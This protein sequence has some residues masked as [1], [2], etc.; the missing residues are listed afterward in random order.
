MEAGREIPREERRGG[1]GVA[2]NESPEMRRMHH[3]CISVRQG[4]YN[5]PPGAFPVAGKSAPAAN[6]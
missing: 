6:S 2:R 3:W 1:A 4:Q 5:G